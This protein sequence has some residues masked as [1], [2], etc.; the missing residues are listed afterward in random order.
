MFAFHC[1]ERLGDKK[2]VPVLLPPASASVRSGIRLPTSMVPV[3]VATGLHYKS[4]S[5]KKNTDKYNV[6]GTT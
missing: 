1:V 6:T 4:A 5:N 3:L 2:G